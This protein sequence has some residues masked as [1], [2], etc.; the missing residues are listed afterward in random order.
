[1]PNKT[2]YII[3]FLIILLSCMTLVVASDPDDNYISSDT[4]TNTQ[5]VTDTENNNYINDNTNIVQIEEKNE[6]YI[7]KDEY[8]PGNKKSTPQEEIKNNQAELIE[9]SITLNYN[10]NPI[11]IGTTVTIRG[12]F[13]AN[14]KDTGAENIKI[15]DNNELIDTINTTD[16]VGTIKYKYTA[17]TSGNHVLDFKFEANSTHQ[18]SQATITIPVNIPIQPIVEITENNFYDYFDEEGELNSKLLDNNTTY[19]FYSIPE[20]TTQI[21]LTKLNKNTTGKNITFAGTPDFILTNKAIIIES[22][23]NNFKL[24]NITIIYTDEYQEQDYI[25]IQKVTGTNESYIDNCNITA[26]ITRQTPKGYPYS[27]ISTSYAPVIISNSYIT[28]NTVESAVD[29]E[30][31]SEN[32]GNNNVIPIKAYST[33][34]IINNTI[35]IY[36]Q[37]DDS[38]YPTLY[39]IRLAGHASVM[40]ENNI[41]ISGGGWLYA[42]Q[43]MANNVQVTNNHINITGVNYTAGIMMENV[44]NNTIDNNTI[45]LKA[46][47]SREGMLNEPCTYGITIID[48]KCGGYAYTETGNAAN[49]KI[50]NNNITCT[51]YNMYG[52]EEFGGSN[53]TIENNTF[54]AT[55]DTAMAIGVIGVNILIN[56][57]TLTAN[58]TSFSGT[59]VDFLGARTTGVYIGRGTNVT[60]TNNNINSTYTGIYTQAQNI[61]NI[62][63]N[64][65]T[66]NY[67]YTILIDPTTNN[68][69]VDNNHL[70][71]P[72]RL[73]DESI[74]DYGKNNTVQNN[75][76]IPDK[77]YTLKVDTTE[78]TASTTTTITASIYYGTEYTQETATNITKGKITFKVNGKTLKDT[79]GKVIYAKIVNGTATIEDYEVPE[80]WAKEGTTIQAVYSGSND[81]EKM[82]SDKTEITITPTEPTIT[83]ENITA[84]AGDTI[85]L[86]A[87][88][89]TATTVNT[90][91]VVFK[92]NGKTV[93]DT[94]GKVIY[95]KVTNNQVNFTY[96][97][98][99][100]MKA[101]E[102]N[103][104]ATFISSDYDKLED[105]KTLTV[106]V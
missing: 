54:I 36:A 25:L 48:Y 27:V 9:T 35:K 42:I 51:A 59:T 20:E 85:T 80:S 46:K 56:N 49:N 44:N 37:V 55:G 12:V 17:I 60:A 63:N 64:N 96:T 76:P 58:G 6:K 11:G 82:T 28:V 106:T 69:I 19:Y 103:L 4:T 67:N 50:T 94:N 24:V 10:G 90:G 70:V 72:G 23:I 62:K 83:T 61:A 45:I 14:N 5:T 32:Y 73:G 87:T 71:T 81:L 75:Q 86:T 39:G 16:N 100:D 101:K 43:P 53:T 13:K 98:P 26:N 2:K 1:M 40:T 95:A 8:N 22:N 29:W 7:Q 91:K 18:A 52:I 66:T 88:I 102:Y 57:N 47:T 97:L 41:T 105:V 93:K 65:I 15:Y 68:T 78:F 104:T 33:I 92:I 77:Q 21:S 38:M 74:K 34:T 31:G 79:N 99:S 30:P 89:N 84:S 3:I